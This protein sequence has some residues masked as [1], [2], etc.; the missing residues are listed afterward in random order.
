MRK[1]T[2]K[3]L[4]E[5]G[6]EGGDIGSPPVAAETTEGTVLSS[7]T[8]NPGI[9]SDPPAQAQG[10][11]LPA[12]TGEA[13][14]DTPTE[15]RWPEDWRETYAKGN[16]K[17]LARLARFNSPTDV[18]DSFFAAEKKLSSGKYKSPL[19]N[20]PSPEQL[21]EWRQQN[22]IPDNPVEYFEKLQLQPG[23][24]VGDDDLPNLN[25]FFTVA[26]SA[27]MTPDQ[28]S[29]AVDWFFAGKEA[30]VAS[31]I[32]SD[33]EAQ[34][35]AEEELRIEWGPMYKRNLA[36]IN[37]LLSDAPP[38]AREGLLGGR[39]ADGTPI[40]NSPEMLRWLAGLAIELNPAA[41]VVPGAGTYSMDSIEQELA[42]I[43]DRMANDRDG[44]FKDERMQKRYGELLSAR[45][46]LNGKLGH[47]RG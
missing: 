24:V 15:P 23:M 17:L 38:E 39:L 19:P 29:K 31:R 11:A 1:Y 35:N 10:D 27:N 40:G 21:S 18:V 43:H 2:F 5:V 30:E 22:G 46:R 12:A 26:Q 37:G 44:Y 45:E 16:D 47:A 34:F 14:G 4:D 25:E 42:S 9:S 6:E 7:S 3:Y 20:N 33:K 32:A 13:E 28:V 36:A 41:T 8:E